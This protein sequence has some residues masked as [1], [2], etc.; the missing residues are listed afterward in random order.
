MAGQLIGAVQTL[1]S[2]ISNTK[3]PIRAIV[4]FPVSVSFLSLC[5]SSPSSH[6]LLVPCVFFCAPAGCG[7]PPR[8]FASHSLLVCLW[9]SAGA[10]RPRASHEASTFFQVSSFGCLIARLHLR[11]GPSHLLG[12][13]VMGK[14]Q[15]HHITGAAPKEGSRE[16]ELP[17]SW[18]GS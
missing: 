2:Y 10:S 12:H 9:P 18:S 11:D 16:G 14:P 5:L 6:F 8:R 15:R 4:P 17:L 3:I 1:L 7:M 13:S